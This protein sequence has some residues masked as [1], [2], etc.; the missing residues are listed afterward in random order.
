MGN[1][2][3][4]KVAVVTGAGR[5][6]G[7]GVAL[8]MAE[9]GAKVVV[10][11]LG[12]EVDGSGSSHAPADSVVEEIQARGG[13]AVA[14]YDNMALMEGGEAVMQQ[15]VDAYGQVDVLANCVGSSA[16][17]DDLADDA[18]GLGQG[19]YEQCEV[20]VP[21]LPSSPCILFRQQRSGR[22]VNMTSDAGLGMMWDARTT[23]PRPRR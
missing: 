6:V 18:G 20:R 14:N 8:L 2:L 22:I 19:S 3:E 7:R 1:R 17:Q 10:N 16:R 15:A 11:D 5:G 21:Q 23:Q 9:E 12:C 4:G 13:E